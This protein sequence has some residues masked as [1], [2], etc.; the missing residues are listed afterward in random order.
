MDFA[1]SEEQEMFRTYLRKYLDKQGQTD[2]A[3]KFIDGDTGLLDQVMTGL[4]ELGTTAVNISEEND[5][6]GLGTLDLIPVFEE[7]G[8]A[9]LPGPLLETQALAV[10]LLE[11]YGTAEQQAKYLPEIAAGTRRVTLAW[12]EPFNEYTP[13]GILCHAE[14]EGNHLVIDGVKE[15][16][17]DADLAETILTIVRTSGTDGEDGLTLVLVDKDEDITCDIQRCVDE[18]KHLAKVTFHKKHVAKS[19]I[20]GEEDGGWKL[21]KEGLLHLNAALSSMITGGLE[22]V[23]DMVTEYA[24]IREQFGGPIGRFQAVKHPIVDMKIELESAR[25]LSYYAAWALENDADDKEAAVYSARSFATGAFMRAAAE[26]IQLHGGIG[27]TEEVD[28]HLYLKRAHFYEHYLGSE[29]YYNEQIAAA[30][31]WQSNANQEK[32]EYE[33]VNNN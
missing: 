22:S 9:V 32:K 15:M 14:F 25:S 29:Q 5:G 21:M 13:E 27:F 17:P 23:V 19:Q 18:T 10:P 7:V 33:H 8:R 2:I 24:K 31:G 26:N 1:L 28:C 6:L 12:L 4:A 16:V 11:K 20:L 30:L 3:R